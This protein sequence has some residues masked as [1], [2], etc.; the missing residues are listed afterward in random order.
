MENQTHGTHNDTSAATQKAVIAGIAMLLQKQGLDAVRAAAEA[1]EQFSQIAR[2]YPNASPE[3]LAGR[4]AEAFH[5]GTFNISAAWGGF[6]QLRA[7]TTETLGHPHDVADILIQ[8][9]KKTVA[10]V[11]SKYCGDVTRTTRAISEKKYSGLQKVVPSDQ[12]PGVQ[13]LAANWKVDGLGTH[14]YPD[15]ARTASDRISHGKAQ[16]RPLTTEQ[17]KKLAADPAGMGKRLVVS[18]SAKMVGRAAAAGAI[19]N[20]TVTLAQQV[21]S[22]RR[23]ETTV[24]DAAKVV[25]EAAAL[26]A[27]TGAVSTGVTLGLK[28]VCKGNTAAMVGTLAADL[29]KDGV[30]LGRGQINAAEFGKRSAESAGRTGGTLA[31]MQ[32]GAALGTLICPG[33]GTLVGGAVGSAVGSFAGEAAVSALT[34]RKPKA[35]PAGMAEEPAPPV[36]APLALPWAGPWP[37]MEMAM[38]S[39]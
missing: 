38:A 32:A 39:D 5:A 18:E 7:V 4:L 26:G 33:V 10:Q 9:G 37:E 13:K 35:E 20:G 11:Q 21:G 34:R 31:G 16:S 24:Q 15:T 12:A 36:C 1:A 8:Q 6:E 25:G 2:T 23:K 22:V 28:T 29:V 14:D 17:A 27:L 30:A 3:Q 19:M